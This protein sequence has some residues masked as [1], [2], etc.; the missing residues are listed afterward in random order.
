VASTWVLALR[1]GEGHN[2]FPALFSSQRMLAHRP[3]P[4]NRACAV[5]WLAHDMSG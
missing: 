3:H 4:R 5:L 2:I 1:E